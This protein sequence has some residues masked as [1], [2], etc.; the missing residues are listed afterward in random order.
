ME[1]NQNLMKIIRLSLNHFTLDNFLLWFKKV[2][3]VARET[4][5]FQAEH[6]NW[7]NKIKSGLNS[8]ELW[9]RFA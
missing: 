9:F 8:A 7:K 4:K 5:H 1:N 3:A 2:H 6:M